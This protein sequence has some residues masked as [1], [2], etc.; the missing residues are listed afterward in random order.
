MEKELEGEG[1]VAEGCVLGWG[2]P[3][4]AEAVVLVTEKAK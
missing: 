1:W 4:L 2:L 3:G